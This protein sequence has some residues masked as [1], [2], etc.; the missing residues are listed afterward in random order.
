MV[1]MRAAKGYLFVELLVVIALVCCVVMLMSSTLSTSTTGFARAALD[2]LYSTC[3]LA[4]KRAMMLGVAQKI[5]FE[6]G[7]NAYHYDRQRVVLPK[8]VTFGWLP[9]V[10]GPPAHPRAG[11]TSA[12]TFDNAMIVFHPDGVIS[13]G[14]VYLVDAK[15]TVLYALSSGVGHVS[16]LRKYRYAKGWQLL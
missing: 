12:C 5:A 14:T 6:L 4:Q 3:L 13:S 11:L 9:D 15:K 8:G 16:F 2:E 7:A 1:L 10:K